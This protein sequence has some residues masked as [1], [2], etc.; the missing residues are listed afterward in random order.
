MFLT[1]LL[2]CLGVLTVI[3]GCMSSWVAAQQAPAGGAQGVFD[4]L[5]AN[6]DPAMIRNLADNLGRAGAD[7]IRGPEYELAQTER[8]LTG[9]AE[10]LAAGRTPQAVYDARR[11]I[12]EA[13]RQRLHNEVERRSGWINK[14]DDVL[15]G[16]ARGVMDRMIEKDR[17]ADELKKAIGTAA[18]QQALVN[19]GSM[20]R[21][22]ALLTYLAEPKNLMRFGVTVSATAAGVFVGYHGLRVAA[23]YVE[24]HLDKPKLVS[25]TSRYTVWTN[26]KEYFGGGKDVPV[27]MDGVVLPQ[28]Q[29]DQLENFAYVLKNARA[30]HRPLPSAMFVGPPGTGKTHALKLLAEFSELDY[31][32]MKGNGFAQFTKAQ[33]HHEMSKL[34]MWLE[35]G[36]RP[37]IL[38]IDEGD[39]LLRSRKDTDGDTR[40]LLNGFLAHT[41][42]RSQ[43]YCIVITTNLEK[44]LDAAVR[45]RIKKRIFFD[46]PGAEER[47]K[48][49]KQELD[50]Q[51]A[52]NDS[53]TMTSDIDESF[54]RQA[55]SSLDGLSGRDLYQ[56]AS[57]MFDLA[58]LP[59]YN[60]MVTREA[61][62]HC[63]QEVGE[64]SGLA[65][66]SAH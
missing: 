8:E 59:K 21:F 43:K 64:H 57:D 56:A 34:F 61:F 65:L 32:I 66:A 4:R 15:L 25:E 27:S 44:E 2:R 12:L 18:A 54:L 62:D 41:G 60:N 33:A 55:V 50:K 58:C 38:F 19:R 10:S 40:S 63:M 49:L 24:A 3:A 9:L 28:K 53:I 37:T 5:A 1:G 29:R 11:P 42:T 46:L 26:I 17:A 23:N 39:A 36:S 45:S 31:A 51:L 48:I 35:A 22:Q 30:S 14:A 7:F 16:A 52:D 13:K 20:E 6:V 47:Y